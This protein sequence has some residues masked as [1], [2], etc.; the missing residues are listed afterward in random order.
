MQIKVSNVNQVAWKDINVHANL[1]ENLKKLEEIAYNLWWVWNSDAKNIFRSIDRE[2]WH[3]AQSNPIVLLHTLSYDKIVEL[4]K[5]R[6]FMRM[7]DR[8]Y[9]DFCLRKD[10]NGNWKILTWRL[11]SED[12]ANGY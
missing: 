1:P 12:K 2:A 11:S 7:L 10:K 5:D 9:E 3:E 6:N 8:T 4:G